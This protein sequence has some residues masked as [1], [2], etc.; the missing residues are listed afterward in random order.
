V[1]GHVGVHVLVLG[2]ILDEFI[3]TFEHEVDDET[4]N[5]QRGVWCSRCR[6]G[7]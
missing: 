2:L 7:E 4:V 6:S 1:G 5:G 3:N